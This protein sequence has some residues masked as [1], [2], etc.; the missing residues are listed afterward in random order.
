[1]SSC[2]G[3]AGGDAVSRSKIINV[4]VRQGILWIGGEAYPLHNIA[5]VQAVELAP[6]RG[7]AVG[8]FV[9]E[10]LVWAALGAGGIVALRFAELRGSEVETFTG[11]IAIGALALALISMIRLLVALARRTFYA[12]VIETSGTPHTAVISPDEALL[13]QLV[14]QIMAAISNPRDPRTQ[15]DRKIEHHHHY[16]HTYFGGQHV[17]MQGGSNNVGIRT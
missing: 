13:N 6:R 11:Y 2:V 14:H 12:L 4:G 7:R 5:R 1:M 15:F 16:G 3:I 9:K 10:I 8:T 17:T